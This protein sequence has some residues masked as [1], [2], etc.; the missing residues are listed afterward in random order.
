MSETGLIPV[1]R[2]SLPFLLALVGGIVAYFVYSR[3]KRL[4]RMEE[5]R[6]QRRVLYANL[7]GTIPLLRTGDAIANANYAKMKS[8]II[9]YG[10]D[11]S[12]KCM[13]EF[14]KLIE[15]GGS[16]FNLDAAVRIESYSRLAASLRRDVFPETKLD[17]EQ[18]RLLTPFVNIG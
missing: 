16:G 3:Q 4:D 11:D 2:E 5:L 1:L 14:A 13:K 7:I 12:V 8:E 10:S 9:L 17:A 18:L 6:G 15:V